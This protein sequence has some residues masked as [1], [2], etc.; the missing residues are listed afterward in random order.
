MFLL[1]CVMAA[2]SG[3]STGEIAQM[4][5]GALVPTVVAINREWGEFLKRRV[6]HDMAFARDITACKAPDEVWR[7]YADFWAK[8]GD[9]YQKELAALARLGGATVAS[10]EA[11]GLHVGQQ[12]A[13]SAS[14]HTERA[15]MHRS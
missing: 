7:T 9:D 15:T 14:G 4:W 8:V 13:A 2:D 10:S 11:A 3:N 6:E 12:V 5:T 1:E